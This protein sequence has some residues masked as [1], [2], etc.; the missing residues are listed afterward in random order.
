MRDSDFNYQH[1]PEYLQPVS[2]IIHDAKEDLM[3]VN[4]IQD[5]DS[6]DVGLQKLLEAKDAF[7]RAFVVSV[8]PRS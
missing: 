2:K 7:V 3:H 4:N 8:P 1:L 6:F 5:T